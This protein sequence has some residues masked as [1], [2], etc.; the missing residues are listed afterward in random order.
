[1][2]G[3]HATELRIVEVASGTAMTASEG[4][5]I[6]PPSW[7]P[8]GKRLAFADG[9]LRIYDV[10]DA[11]LTDLSV[12]ATGVD[13]SPTD[14]KLALV[15]DT[16]LSVSDTDGSEAELLFEGGLSISTPRWSPNGERVAFTTMPD[17][18]APLQLLVLAPG[19]EPVA[20]GA[21]QEPAWSPDGTELAYARPTEEGSPATDIYTVDVAGG[22]PRRLTESVTLDEQ[23]SWSPD[24][25]RIAYLARP[26]LSTAFLCIVP[27][28]TFS[29]DCLDLPQGLA[30]LSLAWSPQ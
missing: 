18:G 14:G 20:L 8:D 4:S 2:T 15:S 17:I 24:G 19:G 29:A 12:S 11:E 9:T 16:E 23:P 5:A 26:D 6:S 3:D 1:M 30:P 13:W 21:G 22:E 10:E 7:S 27:L 25:L 28:D